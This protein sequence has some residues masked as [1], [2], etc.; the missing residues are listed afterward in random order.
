M[1]ETLDM[2]LILQTAL[3]EIGASMDLSQ[4][5]VQMQSKDSL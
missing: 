1:R 2:D 4:I 5:E 3:R